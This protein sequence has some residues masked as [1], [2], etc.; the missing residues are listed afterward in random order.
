MVYTYP[1]CGPRELCVTFLAQR[2]ALWQ[3]ALIGAGVTAAILVLGAA[4]DTDFRLVN[5][6]A[7]RSMQRWLFKDLSDTAS[8]NAPG[9]T[10][11]RGFTWRRAVIEVAVVGLR[12]D[13][14]VGQDLADILSTATGD[15]NLAAHVHASSRDGTS[16]IEKPPRYCLLSEYVL[17]VTDP[18]VPTTLASSRAV[19]PPPNTH[20][21]ATWASCITECA[22]SVTSG[23]SSSG[24]VIVPSS[25]E[26]RYRVI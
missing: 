8:T 10:P 1:A 9:P 16:T 17:S 12:S 5:F 13:E 4:V 18:S 20:T 14:R 25:N 19:S 7:A 23:S 2:F 15:A 3:S 11:D 26:I 22:A 21:P 24:K 6:R